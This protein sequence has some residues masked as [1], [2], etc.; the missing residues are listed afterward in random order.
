MTSDVNSAVSGDAGNNAATPPPAP[1]PV[2]ASATNGPELKPV[3][4]FAVGVTG[5]RLERM[6]GADLDKIR[7]TVADL[8]SRV[9]L[10]ADDVGGK[11]A[12]HFASNK[13]HLR[14][15]TALADGA[16][17]IAAEVALAAGWRLDACLP[18]ARDEYERDF[19]E[20]EHRESFHRLL[21]QSAATFAL[22]GT[23]ADAGASY[24]AVGHVLLDQVDILLALWDGEPGRGRGGTARV[25]AEA[26][27]RHIPVVHIDVDGGSAPVL[28]WSGLADFEIEQPTID[29]VPRATIDRAIPFAVTT[30]IAPPDNPVDRRMLARFHKERHRR[31]TPAIPYPL[32]LAMTGARALRKSDF[33]SP[34]AEDCAASLAALV[35]GTAQP[36]HYQGAMKQALLPRY[37]VADAA[38]TYFAQVFRSGFVANFG[39]AAFAVLLALTGLLVPAYKL[40]LIVAELV[41][42]AIIFAN[43]RAGTK[44]GWHET[45]MDDRHLAE[46]LRALALTSTLAN[47]NLRASSSGESGSIPGWVHWLARATARELGLPNTVADHRYLDS[48]RQTS[49][50]LVE[51]QIAYHHGNAHRMHKLEHRLHKTGSVL[52][53]GT[54]A[55]CALWI[56]AK[57]TGAPMQLGAGIGITELVTWITAAM[58]ALGAAIYGIRMQGD[59][60]GIAFRSEVTVA[61]LERLKRSLADESLDYI[62]L[63]ARLRRLSEI[64]LADVEHWRTT[65]QARPLALPG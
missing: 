49:L 8:L 26:I 41:V 24:E 54:A 31:Y 47:L 34:A 29:T 56:G 43:T 33:T 1:I 36:G 2:A 16:D 62:R 25:V 30:L 4:C 45:W 18:F 61:R 55:A 12:A 42:I 58:P 40:T 46:Q 7:I 10:A 32:L 48:V 5:H 9:R 3:L 13:P 22:S 23:R 38:S 35:A 20:G 37:G 28:L 39:L 6:P 53:G 52:F 64:M 63:M 15:V 51:E 57:L 60:V 14:L 19:A 59:F 21:D 27:A 11:H 65:Y 50:K 44:A 17:T